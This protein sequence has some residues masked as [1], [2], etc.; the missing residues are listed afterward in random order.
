MLKKLLPM[1]AKNNYDVQLVTINF[2]YNMHK[3]V[4]GENTLTNQV[5]I[6]EVFWPL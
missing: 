2:Q 1:F 3:S 4:D 5:H 6:Y